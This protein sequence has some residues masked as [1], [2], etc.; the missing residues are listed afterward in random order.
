MSEDRSAVQ[1]DVALERLRMQER[2]DAE[3]DSARD[4]V[5]EDRLVAAL[6]A[7]RP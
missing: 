1:L 3:N 7:V 5:A 6:T 2:R 4:H